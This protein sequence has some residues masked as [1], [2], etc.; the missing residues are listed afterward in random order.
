MSASLPADSED[1]DLSP[2]AIALLEFTTD[3]LRSGSTGAEP[4]YITSKDAYLWA[5]IAFAIAKFSSAAI[6][7]N[8]PSPTGARR[9]EDIDILASLYAA[10]GRWR[11]ELQKSYGS[12]PSLQPDDAKRRKD[13]PP[14]Q[15]F[16]PFQPQIRPTYTVCSNVIGTFIN[17]L[18]HMQF[19]PKNGL[20][21]DDVNKAITDGYRELMEKDLITDPI[22]EGGLAILGFVPFSVTKKTGKGQA[23]YLR[24]RALLWSYERKRT[25][26]GHTEVQFKWEV[27]RIAKAIKSGLASAFHEA[28]KEG[29]DEPPDHPAVVT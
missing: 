27:A 7:P 5:G 21:G 12:L 2:E 24:I 29:G 19:L 6:S 18:S 25:Q 20:N 13:A 17:S 28:T 10:V 4:L 22:L 9:L 14:S 8:P 3:N 16:F 15:Q 11:P 23:Q 1:L 26:A